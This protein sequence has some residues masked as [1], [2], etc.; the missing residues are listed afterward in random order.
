[1]LSMSLAQLDFVLECYARDH[2]REYTF[3]RTGTGDPTP[4]T[5]TASWFN[6]LRGNA[7][8]R[9]LGPRLN[10]AAVKKYRAR[11]AARFGLRG[12]GKDKV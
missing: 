9:F 2:P 10:T 3:S 7:L 11:Q 8:E 6:I 5:L 4:A 1:M 12:Q